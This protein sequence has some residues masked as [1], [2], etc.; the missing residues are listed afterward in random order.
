MDIWDA[1]KLLLF[2]GFVIPWF[3]TLKTYDLL[4]PSTQQD[5]AKRLVD[6]IAY[7][8]INNALLLWPLFLVETS[9]LRSIHPVAYGAFYAF[10]LLIAPALWGTYFQTIT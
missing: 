2:I 3:V 6:A 1:N 7:S 9:R 10:A 5:S 8:C 4:L